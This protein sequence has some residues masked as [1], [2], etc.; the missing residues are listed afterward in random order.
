LGMTVLPT[1]WGATVAEEMK[2]LV[3]AGKRG[4]AYSLGLKYPGQLGDPDF[5]YF[6]GIAAI[7]AGHAG[8]GVLALERYLLNFPE[9]ERARLDIARGYFVL[10]EDVRAREEFENIVAKNSPPGIIVTINRY[11][12]A[13][14]ARQ[15]RN[16]TTSNIYVEAG[17]GWDSNVNSGISSVAIYLPTLGNVLVSATG[18]KTADW[19]AHLAA[20][21]QVTKPVAPG[22]LV[23][24]S[25]D[26][27]IKNHFNDTAFDQTAAGIAGGVTLL[28]DENI[29]R[30]NLIYGM[31]FKVLDERV[32]ATSGHVSI[33]TM[34]L[35]KGLEFRA[36]VVMACDDEI[37][38]LQERIETVG[39]DAD[40]Q[41]VYDTERHLLYV[42]CTRARDHLLVTSV[43][44]A[45]EFVNDMLV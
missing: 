27:A 14:R 25:G 12:D 40:L 44:P 7:D 32:E 35:A 10:G 13:I 38:P 16:Q 45:S 2:A 37:I 43:E 31:A 18:T 6:F 3:E 5:D 15:G 30:G 39:D 33:S 19:F 17:M 21:A 11:R 1:V 28:R 29:Y 34:H 42:A 4:E 20:G 41:E 23:S 24:I 22:I 36:V 26:V 8:I 9:N